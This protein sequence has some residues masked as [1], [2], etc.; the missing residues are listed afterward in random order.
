MLINNTLL[1]LTC[2]SPLVAGALTSKRV[3]HDHHRSALAKRPVRPSLIDLQGPLMSRLSS[4]VVLALALL[5]GC[6]SDPHA[7]AVKPLPSTAVTTATATLVDRGAVE[8]LP[9]TVRASRFATL[10]ARVPGVVGRITATPGELDAAGALLV[11]LDAKEI[12]AKRDQA[13]AVAA[14][15]AADFARAT[16]LFEKQA[17][18]KAEYDAS[19]ARAAGSAAA[20]AEAEIMVGYTTMRAPFAGVVVR[21]HAEI[22]DLLAPGRPV[23]DFE[24]PASLRLEVEVPESLA[25]TVA[26]GTKL[27]VQI[28]AAGFD[29]EAPVVEVTPAADPVSRS[30]LVKLALPADI[31]GLRSGQFG[32]VAIAT[33]GGRMLAVPATAVFRRGQID[34]VF[35]IQDGIARLRLV[36]TGGTVGDRIALR[37]GLADGE[38]VVTSDAESLIDGQPVTVR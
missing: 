14:Q 26:M 7:V 19:Q 4:V 36:R 5:S 37:A 6:G 29:A 9:G 12:A 27:L 24:D 28:G 25:G 32:R 16:V 31:T 20:A 33:A 38:T 30:V 10:Q 35:V 21:K 18:T 13:K 23:I 8:L 2:P 15:T 22:G 1:M 34:A 17:V 11:E 3:C